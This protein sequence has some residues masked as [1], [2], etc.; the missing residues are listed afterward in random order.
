M[1]QP[2]IPQTSRDA[3][4]D[5]VSLYD[6]QPDSSVYNSTAVER[7]LSLFEEELNQQGPQSDT[8]YGQQEELEPQD[9]V[10]PPSLYNEGQGIRVSISFQPQLPPAQ[11]GKKH[12]KNARA[13]LVNDFIYIHE[14]SDAITF[15]TAVFAKLGRTDLDESVVVILNPGHIRSKRFKAAY[16]IDRI[17]P[18]ALDLDTLTVYDDMMT[19]A[20][21]RSKPEIKLTIEEKPLTV[22]SEQPRADQGSSQANKGQQTLTQHKNENTSFSDTSS[23]TSRQHQ[24]KQRRKQSNKKYSESDSSEPDDVYMITAHINV[25]VPKMH[26]KG[27]PKIG[28]DVLP[29]GPA[30]FSITTAFHEFLLELARSTP[31]PREAL[32]VQSLTWRP[33]K[34]KDAPERSLSSE[35]GYAALIAYAKERLSAC[36]VYVTMSRPLDVPEMPWNTGAGSGTS[37]NIHSTYP[38]SAIELNG[39]ELQSSSQRMQLE[40]RLQPVVKQLEQIHFIGCCTKH[41]KIRCYQNTADQLHYELDDTRLKVWATRIYNHKLKSD[42]MYECPPVSNHFNYS[43]SLNKKEAFAHSTKNTTVP[44]E[45]LKGAHASPPAPGASPWVPTMFQ[46]PAM[47]ALASAMTNPMLNST[48]NHFPFMSYTQPSMHTQP[49][50]GPQAFHTQPSEAHNTSSR[51][52][53]FT[54]PAG[55]SPDTSPISAVRLSLDDWCKAYQVGQPQKSKL[56]GIGFVPGDKGIELIERKD[57]SQEGF[58][59]MEWNRIKELNRKY[60]SDRRHGCVPS[61]E[62]DGEENT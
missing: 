50:A 22:P 20:Q 59:L 5:S 34:P 12:R 4:Q 40:E 15:F 10:L 52:P 36:T 57:W 49:M 26:S 6:S 54:A 23:S 19:R 32:V 62:Q 60:R 2:P 45:S 16:R 1:S 31:C 39:L 43:T 14:M 29:A 25:K 33:E 21:E 46:N 17:Q 37:S 58:V 30:M 56:K 47:L 51:D 42:A 9:I 44:G 38:G 35:H 61:T 53:N 41:P 7:R 8:E 48:F 3:S 27:R 13:Q 11:A 28:F 24:K 55:P 18:G